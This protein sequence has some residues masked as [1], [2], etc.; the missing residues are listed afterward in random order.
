VKEVHFVH[1]YGNVTD[2]RD[3]RLPNFEKGFIG[4]ARPDVPKTERVDTW[5]FRAQSCSTA[6]LIRTFSA[7]RFEVLYT[8]DSYYL[9]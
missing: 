2:F 3:K 4:L 8:Q 7:R 9:N 1:C 6:H 5:F